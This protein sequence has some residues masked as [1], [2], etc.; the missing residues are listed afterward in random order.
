[1]CEKNYSNFSLFVVDVYIVLVVILNA[2][3][4]QFADAVKDCRL[5]VSSTSHF[6]KRNRLHAHVHGAVTAKVDRSARRR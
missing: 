4:Q 1:M 3:I 6:C 2:A 5:V